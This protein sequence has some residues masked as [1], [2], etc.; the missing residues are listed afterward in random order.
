MGLISVNFFI[1]VLVALISYFLFPD[2]YKW[3]VLLGFSFAY[4]VIICGKFI[5]FMLL[6]ILTTYLA[7]RT[8]DSIY[9]KMTQ[10]VKENKAVWDRDMRKSYKKK[11]ENKAKYVML[12]ALVFNF[13]ILAFFKYF[14]KVMPLGIS[15]YTFQTMGYLIDVYHEKVEAEKNIGKVAL[16]VSFFPQIIQGP[17]GMYPDLAEQ[18]YKPHRF[19]LKRIEKAGLLVLWGM[20]KKMVIADRAVG[21]INLVTADTT[22]Y[23]GSYILLAVLV[24][25]LQLYAD[26]SGGIDIVRGIAELFGITMAENFRRPYFSKS[27][28]EY[29]HR[30]HITL[31]NWVRTYVFYPLSISKRFLKMGKWLNNHA[32][33]HFGK[34]IPTSIASLITFLIIGVWHGANSKYIA[35]GLWNGLVIMITELLQPVTDK[36]IEKLHINVKSKIYGFVCIVW[37]FLLVLV[38]YYFDVAANCGEAV[39]MMLKSVADFNI[40][41]FSYIMSVLEQSGLDM[42]DAVTVVLG[43]VVILIVSLIQE[44]K[45]IEIRSWIL[46]QNRIL[47]W[48]IIYAAIFTV[49]LMGFYGPGIG[50]SDFVYMQF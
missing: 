25:A 23:T 16:Y 47:R 50:A 28:T 29:W 44:K 32:G 40:M 38:G 12:A 5:P 2:R 35:F 48:G 1:F 22:A 14:G 30:W 31:G 46:C 24:Y 6:T 19:S 15:F 10:T 45:N 4:Y 11:M 27:L 33:K 17:I 21:I 41:D 26:F 20:F 13:G 34:V 36:V 49:L 37:T 3:V 9:K 7:T 18:L 42:V 43:G 8:I 39:N